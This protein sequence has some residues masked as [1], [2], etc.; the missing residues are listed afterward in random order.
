[1]T[2]RLSGVGPLPQGS[3]HPDISP[4]DIVM[5]TLEDYN[6]KLSYF[7]SYPSNYQF[8]LHQKETGVR[9]PSV[10]SGL[11]PSQSVSPGISCVYFSSTF[12]IAGFF[13]ADY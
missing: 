5:P 13:T 10:V 6:G 3:I 4:N 7:L 1:M 12:C 11:F 8:K 2:R 9:K